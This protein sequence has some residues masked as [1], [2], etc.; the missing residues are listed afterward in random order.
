MTGWFVIGGVAALV[1]SV[2]ALTLAFPMSE[3]AP[4][5]ADPRACPGSN[6]E[7][8]V[9]TAAFDVELPPDVAELSFR[10][11]VHPMF[12]EHTLQISFRTTPAGLRTFLAASRFAAPQ[13]VAQQELPASDTCPGPE[14]FRRA[15][16]VEDQTAAGSSRTLVVDTFDP[17]HPLAYIRAVD[18]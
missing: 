12:D 16:M 6:V 4:D 10:S 5:I 8:Q 2:I 9:I 18:L 13:T 3:R 7:L 11:D 17:A 1:V 15:L 14:S